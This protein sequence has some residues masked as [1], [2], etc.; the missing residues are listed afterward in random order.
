MKPERFIPVRLFGGPHHGQV[1][2]V[3]MWNREDLPSK[4]E[5]HGES[6]RRHGRSHAYILEPTP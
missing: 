6:Y 2:A 1:L 4:V 3:E 5:F